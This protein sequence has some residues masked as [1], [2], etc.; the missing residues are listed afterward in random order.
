MGVFSPE[1]LRCALVQAPGQVQRGSGEGSGEGL[2]NF[3][4]KISH[5]Q[6]G[7]WRRLRRG[8]GAEP[9]QV[10]QWFRRGFRGE[11]LGG[12]G[13]EPSQIQQ[14]SGDAKSLQKHSWLWWHAQIEM[15]NS[16]MCMDS[17][18]KCHGFQGPKVA[19]KIDRRPCT[20]FLC[21]VGGAEHRLSLN[22]LLETSSWR[23]VAT[24]AAV[25]SWVT[26]FFWFTTFSLVQGEARPFTFSAHVTKWFS[27]DGT[28]D[29][30]Q[31]SPQVE[32]RQQMDHLKQEDHLRLEWNGAEGGH[33]EW[34]KL[35]SQLQQRHKQ[36]RQCL[37][38]KQAMSPGHGGNCSQSPRF[39]TTAPGRVKF[40]LG[41]NG[42]CPSSNT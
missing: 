40:L 8:F 27:A 10:Q 42:V 39:L 34:F 41:R 31:W 19:V 17:H 2:G 5:V 32:A 33:L 13:A 25:A 30:V 14:G 12:F 36:P 7:F 3:G 11:N 24:Q 26:G 16:F 23:L 38:A 6:H 37:A 4:A 18:D 35:Q 15:C 21:M 1:Q 29:R 20:R 28:F 9:G 22:C